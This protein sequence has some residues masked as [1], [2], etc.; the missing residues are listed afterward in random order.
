MGLLK[1]DNESVGD[2]SNIPR[3]DRRINRTRRSL[4]QAM[5]ELS[6]ERG[7]EAV[8]IRDLTERADIGYATFFRHYADKD[9]L[10]EDVLEG[11]LTELMDLIIPVSSEPEKAFTLLFEQARNNQNLYRILLSRRG[12]DSF[13]RRVHEVGR[14]GVLQTHKSNPK[15]D[16]PP[17][18]AAHHMVNA[19]LGIMEWWLE[20]GMPYS[21]KRMGSIISLLIIQPSRALAFKETSR[22]ARTSTP[23]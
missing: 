5:I 10:L 22:R 14:K 17:E 13:L 23:R 2:S 1:P 20:Q 19:T 7:Y 15:A 21:P 8:T 12:S 6:L 3:V 18:I 4:I 16:V 11:T 9:A